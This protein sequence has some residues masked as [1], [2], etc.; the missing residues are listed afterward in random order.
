MVEIAE[1]K[2]RDSLKDW[3]SDKPA[4]VSV[5]VAVRTALRVL[6]LIN[7]VQEDARA[8][9][10]SR[11]TLASFRASAVARSASTWPG[12][13]K[14]FNAAARVAVNIALAG[15]PAKEPA[16]DAAEASVYAAAAT[17]AAIEAA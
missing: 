6:P 8:R 5:A 3:L 9:M 15:Y 17:Y 16:G 7:K 1:I 4:T 2:D 14:E 10:L 13:L 12:H 11:L